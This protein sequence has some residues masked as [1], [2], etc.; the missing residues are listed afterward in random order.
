LEYVQEM[1]VRYLRPP[2]PPEPGEIV[3]K[4]EPNK[5]APPA[6]PIVIRNI[7]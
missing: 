1:T 7:L 2:T 6:P 5:V 3:I 4:L